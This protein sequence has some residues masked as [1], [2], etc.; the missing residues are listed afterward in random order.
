MAKMVEVEHYTPD[1]EVRSYR[2]RL[3]DWKKF[4]TECDALEVGEFYVVYGDLKKRWDGCRLM[5]LK[6][7]LVKS[8]YR[9]EME[10]RK[11]VPVPVMYPDDD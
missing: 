11:G 2:T 6:G 3:R 9:I 8:G 1:G 4:C 5:T 10:D 7:F